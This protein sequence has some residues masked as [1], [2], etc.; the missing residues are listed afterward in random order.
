MFAYNKNKGAKE[1]NLLLTEF[2]ILLF[3]ETWHLY[4]AGLIYH[5]N[6][7]HADCKTGATH[8]PQVVYRNVVRRVFDTSDLMQVMQHL[9]L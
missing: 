6:L 3:P 5:I 1:F 7:R 4:K 8:V 9:F 2:V